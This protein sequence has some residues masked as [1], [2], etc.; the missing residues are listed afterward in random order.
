MYPRQIF[1][2]PAKKIFQALIALTTWL[3]I[4]NAIAELPPGNVNAGAKIYNDV[5][6]ACHEVS[7]APTLR[8]IINRPIASVDSFFGYTDGLKT[9]KDLQ[10]S[11]E[12]LDK[13]LTNPGAFAPGTDMVQ[14]IADAQDRANIVAFLEALPPPRK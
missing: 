9:K 12:N 6:K 2:Q 7:I 10:W 5:C 8:G 13:F 14:V 1:I 4:S 3:I 11:K